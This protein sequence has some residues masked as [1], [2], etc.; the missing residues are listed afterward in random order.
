MANKNISHITLL[1][2]LLLLGW[3]DASAQREGF[4]LPA[5]PAMQGTTGDTR[6]SLVT[7]YPGKEPYSLYGHTELRVRDSQHDIFYNYGIFDFTTP[8]FAWR[9]SLGETD[10]LC[11]AIPASYAL[12]GYRNRRVVEQDLNL[13]Q[14]QARQVRHL[15]AQNARPENAVYRY[16]FLSNNCATRPRDIIEQVLGPSLRYNSTAAYYSSITGYRDVIARF[17]KNYPWNQFG[18][19]LALGADLDTAI[20]V[21][22]M[23]FVPLILMDEFSSA[24][25][26]RDGQWQPLVSAS[27]ILA[28]GPEQGDILPPTPWIESPMALA[29]LVLAAAVAITAIET[30]RRRCLRWPDALLH[31]VA[32]LAGCVLWFLIVVSTHEGTTINLNGMWLHPLW[33]VAALIAPFGRLRRAHWHIVAASGIVAALVLLASPVLPQH[34]NPA[35]YPLMA[36]LVLRAGSYC[37]LSKSA[38]TAPGKQAKHTKQ[39]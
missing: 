34:F 6:V 10:Y 14:E 25:V 18:I 36:A 7:I 1:V 35:F 8:G 3:H 19:D 11:G 15:L 16:K 23:T 20:S 2:L 30:R 32:G 29:L 22:Q 9:F 17:S 37:R 26:M 31:L 33:L 13:T 28:D 39:Q 27:R 12:S 21:R 4:G 5:L 24:K 38:R